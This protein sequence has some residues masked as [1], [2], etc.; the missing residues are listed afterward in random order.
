MREND[1]LASANPHQLGDVLVSDP[2]YLVSQE[3]LSGLEGKVP[4]METMHPGYMVSSCRLSVDAE[5][6]SVRVIG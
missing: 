2:G 5:N 3:A 4:G 6:G 1:P